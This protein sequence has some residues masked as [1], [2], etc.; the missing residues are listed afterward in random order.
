MMLLAIELG[1][2]ELGQTKLTDY[3]HVVGFT[4]VTQVT[5][6]RLPFCIFYLSSVNINIKN[7]TI[8]FVEYPKI[9]NILCFSYLFTSTV[10]KLLPCLLFS[11]SWL[12]NR[13]D[14]EEEEVTF[15]PSFDFQKPSSSYL[16][17][18]P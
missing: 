16:L 6:F 7:P 1:D 4:K 2:L 18:L 9:F 17:K 3:Y 13:A 14:F 12:L 5:F 10:S 8:P 15:E 11:C